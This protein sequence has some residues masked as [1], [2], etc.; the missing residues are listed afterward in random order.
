MTQIKYEFCDVIHIFHRLFHNLGI[1]FFNQSVVF[2][3]P[4]LDIIKWREIDLLKTRRIGFPHLRG[5]IIDIRLLAQFEKCI[6]GREDEC[7]HQNIEEL[8]FCHECCGRTGLAGGQGREKSDCEVDGRRDV[9]PE[10]RVEI[11]LFHLDADA[12]I[13]IV[14]D[15][16][17]D[18]PGGREVVNGVILGEPFRTNDGN[19]VGMSGD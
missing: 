15:H 14:L 2:I 8:R 18:S 5:F 17:H 12:Q 1:D 10:C 3:Q 4:H 6:D 19:I 7:C 9:V 16:E 11:L 13:E